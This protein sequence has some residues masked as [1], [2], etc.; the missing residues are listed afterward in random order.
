MNKIKGGYD[1]NYLEIDDG[2]RNLIKEIKESK[3]LCFY[4]N[5]IKLIKKIHNRKLLLSKTNYDGALLF[6]LLTN[7]DNNCG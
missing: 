2:L 1:E 6:L 5:S 4:T 3:N 7:S